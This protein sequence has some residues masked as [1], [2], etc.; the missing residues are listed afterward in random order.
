MRGARDIRHFIR[1]TVEDPITNIL[2]SHYDLDIKQIDV[3]L[4]DDQ[5]VVTYQI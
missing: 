5:I 1:K 3:A 4:A 2:V